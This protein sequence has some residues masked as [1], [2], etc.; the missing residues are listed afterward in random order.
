MSYPL[1]AASTQL[2]LLFYLVVTMN[3]GRARGKYGIKA[4]AV[5][6]N[7]QFER[8]YRIQMNSLEH[9]AF[10]LPAMWLYAL[11]LS[12]LGACVGGIVWV[13]GRIIYGFAYVKNPSS[14]VTGMMIS[15][16][17]QIG[18]FLGAVYGVIK[19]ML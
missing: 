13:L 5:T 15:F 7:E 6:G 9:I 1:T 18:L 14:R 16:L 3:V 19:A 4:P 10:L 11:T 2:V 12:D 17:A 8:A